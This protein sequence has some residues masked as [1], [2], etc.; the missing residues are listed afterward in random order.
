MRVVVA[1]AGGLIGSSLLGVLASEGHEAVRLVRR[2]P[3]SGEIEW[4]PA[5]GELDPA[6]LSGAD[7]VINLGGAGI[8]DERWTRDRKQLILQSRLDVTNLL[9][10]T[11][12]SV[13]KPPS[14]FLS[15]S[16]IGY[17]GDRGDELLTEESPAGDSED[18]LVRVCEDWEAATVPAARAGVRTV[19]LR[20]GLVLDA[21]GGALGKMLLPFKFGL[22]GRLGSG[23][24]WW[25]WISLED[26]VRAIVYL[27]TSGLAGPVN[28]TAPNPVTN[29]DFT[30]ALGDV[31]GRPTA[32]PVPRK[33]LEVVLGKQL[34]AALVFTSARVVPD[35][36][37][38]DG[39][40]FSTPDL[41]EALSQ[42]LG[43]S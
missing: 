28:L 4:D 23:K 24:Q 39:F 7:A 31:L 14:V 19:L 21:D 43:R 1:G 20:T 10:T 40:A 16:A 12:A 18:F 3:G 35:R 15:A 27:L 6:A 8:G 9:A 2:A 17:Y 42:V 13:E 11:I 36:L 34:A 22:G 38:G 32:L 33:G 26:E 5:R 25:S 37:L 41:R 29:A 30:S